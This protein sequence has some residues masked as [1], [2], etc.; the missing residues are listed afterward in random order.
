MPQKDNG[1]ASVWE[2]PARLRRLF[3]NLIFENAA[4]IGNFT[5][6]TN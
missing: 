6:A 5:L 1:L 4:T 3:E 2:K